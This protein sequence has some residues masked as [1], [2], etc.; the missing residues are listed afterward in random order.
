VVR[1]NASLA[2]AEISLK[3]PWLLLWSLAGGWLAAIG[4]VLARF[5]D[6]P[7]SHI[8]AIMKF[9][10]VVASLLFLQ[11]GPWIAG[12]VHRSWRVAATVAITQPLIAGLLATYLLHSVYPPNDSHVSFYAF[13]DIILW[14][15]STT[16]WLV[17][18]ALWIAAGVF[19][20]NVLPLAIGHWRRSWNVALAV[21]MLQPFALLILAVILLFTMG[22]A[23][24]R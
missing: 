7:N 9:P 18:R 3:R 15:I 6:A 11:A 24:P 4:V 12:R 22:F 10:V 19:L 16:F 23:S 14:S 21:A 1:V 13:L 8:D 17:Y 2:K 20:V 5:F